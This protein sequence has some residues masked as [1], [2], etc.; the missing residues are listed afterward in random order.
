[1]SSKSEKPTL[2]GQ[3][4][5]S[6]KRD[7]KTKFDPSAF[8]DVLV[9]GLI[10]SES[11]E[12][13]SKF[14]EETGTTQTSRGHTI[15]KDDKLDYRRYS[16]SLF[17]VLIT[18]TLLAPGGSIVDDDAPENPLSVF[19]TDGSTEAIKKV[20]E[21]IRGLIRRYK[22]LQV[23]LEEEM[24]K[25]LKFIKAFSEENRD[26]LALCTGYFLAF[27]LI[28]AKPLV[29]LTLDGVVKEGLSARFILLTLRTWSSETSVQNMSGG[30][31]KVGLDTEVLRFFPMNKR[32]MEAFKALAA[33]LGDVDQLVAWQTVQQ[34]TSIKRGLQQKVIEMIHVDG[35]DAAAVIEAVKEE[36]EEHD[37]KETDVTTLLWTALMNAI[38]WK[39]KP[40]QVAEQA[41]RHVK[42]YHTVLGEFATTHKAQVQLIV[43]IQNF[44]YDNQ[45]LLKIFN[46]ICLLLYKA[47]VLGED[48]I[49]E[50]YTKA[51]STKGKSV[52]LA[53]MKQ[54]IDWLNEAEEE[55]ESEGE[56]GK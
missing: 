4:I 50:W 28:S 53:Q 12:A 9:A 19:A 21:F 40:D 16:E 6:R 3:R 30:M 18:G 54:F 33:E 37:M 39:S 24:E 34:L 20:A 55:T 29:S 32:T 43:R 45:T 25:V 15:Q 41:L 26:K 36:M 17:D 5:R 27:G 31:R 44:S 46:K 14:L 1:M 23:L 7:E 48:A 35:A 52:F 10:D 49:L 8:R 38:D 22:Y 42:A 47:D 56:E 2:T 51:H 11:L 13:A